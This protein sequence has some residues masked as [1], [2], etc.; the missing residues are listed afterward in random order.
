MILGTLVTALLLCKV[1]QSYPKKVFK[2]AQEILS[3]EISPISKER[4]A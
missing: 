3:A 2:K 4:D 1:R